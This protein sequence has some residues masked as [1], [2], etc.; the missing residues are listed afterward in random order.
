M[1]ELIDH[2]IEALSG[3]EGSCCRL[4]VG[5]QRSAIGL[6]HYVRHGEV[7]APPHGRYIS[8]QNPQHAEILYAV[9][10][11]DDESYEFYM[12]KRWLARITRSLRGGGEI[13]E[14]RRD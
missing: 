4:M 9:F 14:H 3:H 1:T 12:R 11:L 13:G 7:G 5:L 6:L 2:L 10:Y 8:L